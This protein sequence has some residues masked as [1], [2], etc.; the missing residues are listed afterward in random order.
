[1]PRRLG[2]WLVSQSSRPSSLL[3][4]QTSGLVSCAG[5]AAEEDVLEGEGFTVTEAERMLHTELVLGKIPLHT[6]KKNWELSDKT[7]PVQTQ[8]V[9]ILDKLNSGKDIS[10]QKTLYYGQVHVRF[11]LRTY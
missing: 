3:R 9:R 1:M 6:K 2:G 11:I 4:N 7:C 10:A 5:S 8:H